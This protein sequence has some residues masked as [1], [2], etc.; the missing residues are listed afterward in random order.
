MK[1]I[2][3]ILTIIIMLLFTSCGANNNWS[4]N[5]EKTIFTIGSGSKSAM[6]YPVANALCHI[7]NKYN[8][9]NTT[10]CKASLSSGAKYNLDSVNNGKFDM[11]IAQASLQH[12]A[13][14]GLNE[15][16]GKPHK[17]IRTLF[18]IHNEYLTII[19]NND[20][21]KSFSD[22]RGKKVNI[23]NSGS[24]SRTLFARMIRKLRW[25]LDDFAK[26]YEESGS[27]IKKVLCTKNEADAAI[28]IVG[29]P[30]NSFQFMI[31]NCNATLVSLSDSEINSFI[32]LSPQ[33]F[34][35]S[36]IPAGT[37]HKI[38]QNVKT[39]SSQTILIASAKLDNKIIHNFVNI[40]SKHKEEL[41]ELQSELLVID[42]LHKDDPNLAPL[43]EGLKD[44]D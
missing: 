20:N 17:N 18:N 5:R 39:L 44:S 6:F 23:G 24:G 32:S 43:H 38:N 26:I 14:Y 12:D 3:S 9:D 31:D 35:Q 36:T 34:S 7:F 30:N 16:A 2:T 33:Y 15:F 27:N 41:V 13:Y 37:Y 29:H 4:Q 40:I 28:Y 42:F 1:I 8:E 11:G 10:L 22:L 19:S 25:N 21:I